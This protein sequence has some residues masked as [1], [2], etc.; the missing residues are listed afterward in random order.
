MFSSVNSI[1]PEMSPAC[2]ENSPVLSEK[3]SES[4]YV[5]DD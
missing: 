3:L 5:S 4:H 1:P 2:S